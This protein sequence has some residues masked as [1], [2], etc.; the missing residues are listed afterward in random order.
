MLLNEPADTVRRAIEAFFADRKRDSLLLLYFSGHGIKDQDGQLYF[1]LADTQ[2]KLLRATAI[3]AR[4]V[5]E[6]MRY[7]R[8]RQQVLLLDCCYSGAFPRGMIAK[9]DRTVG[10]WDYFEGRGRIVLTASDAVQYAF[11]GDKVKGQGVHSVF[12]H[13]LVQ[14]LETGEADRNRDGVVSLDEVYDYVYDRVTAETPQQ[15]PGK[16]AFGVQG[17][18]ILARNPTVEPAGR[19][20]DVVL[21]VPALV[22]FGASH[23][24]PEAAPGLS[25]LWERLRKTPRR[26]MLFS[27]LGALLVVALLVVWKWLGGTSVSPPAVLP[28]ATPLVSLPLPVSLTDEGCA[29]HR[30]LLE[31]DIREAGGE[32]VE[33]DR[34]RMQVE[35]DCRASPIEIAVR[36]PEQPAYPVEFLDDVS[37]LEVGTEIA[38]ARPLVRAA[39]AYAVGDYA[40]VDRVLAGT[41]GRLSD[42]EAYLLHAQ[43][44]VHLEQ[45]KEARTAFTQVLEGWSAEAES[46]L[47]ARAYSGRGLTRYLWARAVHG[48]EPDVMQECQQFAAADFEAAMAA[49]G[50]RALWRMGRALAT[51]FCSG[52]DKQAA[53]LSD[54]E[55]AIGETD[56]AAPFDAATILGTAAL[57]YLNTGDTNRAAD[58]AER[59]LQRADTVSIPYR[60]LLEI[61]INQDEWEQAWEWYNA[62]WMRLALSGQREELVLMVEKELGGG[63]PA[64]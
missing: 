27:A 51:S 5:N 40:E 46:E 24:E 31:K 8:S 36:M 39:V 47:S 45:H 23:R 64:P 44:L 63:P 54:V 17:E 20:L 7:S 61:D 60:V 59:A 3:Q 13:A 12:T 33:R 1:A 37:T 32:L 26:T 22:P 38:Y 14:G 15:T 57:I 10:T 43:A 30:A 41:T 34:A 29:E 19:P 42:P 28:T 55:A 4:F 9:A 6:V 50:G 35:M 56:N 21:T 2:R 49:Q 53:V 62:C 25:R 48:S 52:P 18:I 16:W 11:E 58:L